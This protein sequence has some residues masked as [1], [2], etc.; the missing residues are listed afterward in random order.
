M[1]W[2]QWLT[3]VLLLIVSTLL[4]FKPDFS[5]KLRAVSDKY[6]QIEDKQDQE[7]IEEKA[8]EVQEVTQNIDQVARDAAQAQADYQQKVDETETLPDI[9][10]KVTAINKWMETKK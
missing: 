7:K 4:F 6:R 5:R 2:Y 3:G 10:S 9:N 1:K 8:E